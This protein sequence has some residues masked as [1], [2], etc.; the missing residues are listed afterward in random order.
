MGDVLYDVDVCEDE[1]EVGSMPECQMDLTEVDVYT[2]LEH[3]ERDLIIAAELGKS[4]L[5]KNEFLLLENERISVDYRDQC[6]ILKQQKHE[7]RQR[8][9]FKTSE[10]EARVAQL[11][12][13]LRRAQEQLEDH[14]AMWGAA[15][16]EKSR[17]VDEMTQQNQK[18]L[19]Q[20]QKSSEAERQLSIQVQQL[21]REFNQRSSTASV[22]IVELESLKEEIAQGSESRAHLEDCYVTMKDETTCLNDALSTATERT[23][24]LERQLHER[25]RE[26]NRVRSELDESRVLNRQYQI[27]IDELR[28]EMA[29]QASYNSNGLASSLFS[30][31]EQSGISN[32]DFLDLGASMT[33]QNGCDDEQGENVGRCFLW[34]VGAV[35]G[36]HIHLCELK[37]DLWETY[38]RVGTI[39]GKIRSFLSTPDSSTG[40]SM[41]LSHSLDVM[42]SLVDD[43]IQYKVTNETSDDFIQMLKDKQSTL[44]VERDEAVGGRNALEVKLAQAKVDLMSVNSQLLEAIQQKLDQQKELEAWQDDMEQMIQKALNERTEQ[45]KVSAL[46]RLQPNIPQTKTSWFFSRRTR[47]NSG[48]SEK[49]S[50]SSESSPKVPQ[51][52][53]FS[54]WLRRKQSNDPTMTSSGDDVT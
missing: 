42:S 5:E 38:Q 52:S 50:A 2:R 9:E 12:S 46:R 51:T 28:E 3:K 36:C 6:E 34:L 20:L 19:S 41:S 30:E 44:M 10:W 1:S 7:L 40:G 8:F 39:S 17:A 11:S 54:S 31:L 33:S 35:N 18:L 27:R 22:K 29:L 26:L 45:M 14:K 25:E 16:R 48:E 32:E 15:E 53:R 21:R 47:H 43:V 23:H 37:Q 49:S 13:D 4:L 24:Q